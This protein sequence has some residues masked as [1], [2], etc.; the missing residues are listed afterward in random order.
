[1]Q[2]HQIKQAEWSGT[3]NTDTWGLTSHWKRWWGSQTLFVPLKKNV[4]WLLSCHPSF[5]SHHPGQ[6]MISKIDLSTSSLQSNP[7]PY[8]RLPISMMRLKGAWQIRDRDLPF[9][10]IFVKPVSSAVEL[11]AQ[12]RTGPVRGMCLVFGWS[13]LVHWGL[14]GC[15]CI[16]LELAFYLLTYETL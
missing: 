9:L 8:F 16:L 5:G 12:N 15:G 3:Q 1:M 6:S 4:P 7:T 10:P 2:G 13:I 14:R 11:R